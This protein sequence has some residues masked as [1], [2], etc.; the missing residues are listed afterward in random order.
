MTIEVVNY[1]DNDEQA[2]RPALVKDG[3]RKWLYI[4]QLGHPLRVRKIAKTERRY[5]SELTLNRK[6]G[7]VPYPLTRAVNKFIRFGRTG[8]MTKS[9]RRFLAE[10]AEQAK[11]E[12]AQSK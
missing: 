10:A 1:A 11:A 7:P 8:S 6:S 3:G 5:M 12:P 9:A 4:C 2:R